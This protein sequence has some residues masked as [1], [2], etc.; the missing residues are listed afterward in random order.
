M[1]YLSDKVSG[2]GDMT[3]R[4]C[5]SEND[6]QIKK[7]CIDCGTS[8]T[9]LWRSGPAGP[10][11]LCNAC[12]IKSR[13]KRRP[14]VPLS[15]ENKKPKTE[16]PVSSKSSDKDENDKDEIQDMVT[17]IKMVLNGHTGSNDEADSIGCNF[18]EEERAAILLMALSYSTLSS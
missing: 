12:G 14:S 4:R 5:T 10:K 15:K 6:S 3:M 2:S 16:S 7:T 11:S 17:R 13:K 1:V 8:K 9:P 18:D